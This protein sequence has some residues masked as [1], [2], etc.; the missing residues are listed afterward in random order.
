MYNI[1]VT[2]VSGKHVLCLVFCSA[3]F[4]GGI[5][6]I[7]LGIMEPS[8][9]FWGGSFLGLA[10]GIFSSINAIIAII[11]F[12]VVAPIVGGLPLIIKHCPESTVKEIVNIQETSTQ[13]DKEFE[14]ATIDTDTN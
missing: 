14:D 8:I 12:N 3:T 1:T 11:V 4:L 10:I 6:G 5:G 7:I 2:R 9:G 13:A